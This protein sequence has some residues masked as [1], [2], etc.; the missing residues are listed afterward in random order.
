[1]SMHAAS[2]WK[3]SHEHVAPV[4]RTPNGSG[5]GGQTLQKSTLHLKTVQTCQSGY[6]ELFRAK[7]ASDDEKTVQISVPSKSKSKVE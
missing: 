2:S 5:Q 6:I 4:R 1:M 3:Q 7:L